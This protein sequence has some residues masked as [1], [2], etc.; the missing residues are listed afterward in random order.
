MSL[1]ELP[2]AFLLALTD[3]LQCWDRP[4]RTQA[5]LALKDCAWQSP[6]VRILC[7]DEM[8]KLCFLKDPDYMRCTPDSR[9]GKMLRE[10]GHYLNSDDLSVLVEVKEV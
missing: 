7:E 1:K 5:P 3:A 6:D 10:M 9:A 8:I 2:L 4:L